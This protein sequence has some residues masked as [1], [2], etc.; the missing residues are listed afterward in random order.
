MKRKTI[1]FMLFIVFCWQYT[2]AQQVITGTVSSADD[3]SPLPGVNVV[4]KGTTIGVITDL[5]GTYS[6]EV[7]DDAT[8]LVF[9]FIGMHPY[10]STIGS[11]TQIDVSLNPDITGLEEIVVVG[12]GTR[13]K[14]SLTG[15]VGLITADDID[16]TP[17][18]SFDQALQGKTSGVQVIQSSGRPGAEAIVRIRGASTINASTDPLYLIDGIP[19][20]S[21]N[22]AALNPN[23]IESISILKDAT[24]SIYGSQ[25]ANGVI[26]ITTKKGQ[27]NK[28]KVD[29]RFMS[30]WT[31]M[32]KPDMN[33]MNAQ[34]KIDFEIG[35]GQRTGY[36]ASQE[37]ID[38]LLAEEHDW[39]ETITR[40]GLMKSH[41][42][43]LSGGSD[44]TTFYISGS[45]F[46]QEGITKGSFLDRYTGRI[47]V[48]HEAS[49]NL[50]FGVNGSIGYYE[51]GELRD[52]R[53][54]QNPFHAM[55]GYNPYEPLKLSDGS[56]NYT[57]YGFN[58]VEAIEKN[59]ERLQ[60]VKSVASLYG[61][62]QIVKGLTL[63]ANAGYDYVEATRQ[64][65]TMP[66]SIL[67][68]Y[69]GDFMRDQWR[70]RI[71]K[72][73][74]S[75][76]TYNFSAGQHNI[77]VKAGVEAQKYWFKSLLV[78]VQSFPADVLAV[79]GA[80]AST[81]DHD[82]TIEEWGLFSYFGSATYDYNQKY[83]VD[84][85]VRR[86]GSSRFGENN[87]WATFSAVGF[88][89]NM[90]QEDFLESVTVLSNL[91]IRGTY[92]SA[93]NFRY[94]KS[95]GGVIVE[96]YYEALGTYSYNAYNGLSASY[97]SKIENPNL[98][99]E[100]VTTL[101]LGADFGLFSERLRGSFAY[102]NRKT[103]DMFF[104]RQVS[105]TSGFEDKVEN[106][107]EMVN[108][109]IEFSLDG[110]IVRTGDLQW[111]LGASITTLKN[112]IT[113][114]YGEDDNQIEDGFGIL[115]KGESAYTFFL[116]RYAGVNPANGDALFYD[117]NGV[118]T[119]E[120]SDADRV[121]MDKT[122]HPKFYGSVTTSVK[123]KGFDLSALLYYN[124]G[125]YVFSYFVYD[126][127]SDGT[128]ITD[129]Q[130]REQLRA[131]KNPGDIT[132]V[133]ETRVGNDRAYE[134]DR[135][136]ENG[137]YIRLRDVTLAYNL[138]TKLISKIKVKG[139]RVYVKGTNLL[140]IANYKGYDPEIG[141]NSS[142]T[143]ASPIGSFDENTYPAVRTIN[144]GIDLSF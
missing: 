37:V 131:W 130:S 6:I 76:L 113:D 19:V 97:P 77:S 135:N 100:T 7:S 83:I 103:S 82:G 29:Y 110:D 49:E 102:F 104:P 31:N 74:S 112:E 98:K 106:I 54:V 137:S 24:A 73:L 144:V 59:P 84:L 45:L 117:K 47:N 108:K 125:N 34:E 93:G 136:L 39:I 109:G 36:A 3:S 69:V 129:N 126:S 143:D 48:R 123:Y 96:P 22:F 41:Q 42:L 128:N 99:W 67:A 111:T 89:W 10:E 4:L 115:K 51:R 17:I 5:E 26:I 55:L 91:K 43:S 101:D 71:R 72:N 141:Y 70:R 23:D 60:Q 127:E 57:H 38:S 87:Q 9:S 58:V 107:G 120:F 133:P 18:A 95:E 80:A 32:T 28:T 13:K 20:E 122:P 66:S 139:L 114:L 118:V 62:W 121:I 14:G 142:E 16:Q 88:A 124:Y 21:D 105:R 25:A 132:D 33:M 46:D 65:F 75:Y 140:T 94:Q 56:Y 35:A 86:D 63:S 138:P 85:V 92:G 1:L 2:Y 90:H 134:T 30:G 81:V 116:V 61:N 40:T 11:Q 8:I 44:K 52:R 79:P 15:S 12:Y 64:T 27:K 119:N 50:D 53:N 68:S 78:G